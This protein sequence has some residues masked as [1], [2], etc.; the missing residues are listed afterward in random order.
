MNRDFAEMLSALSEA[1]AEHPIVSAHALAV[2]GFPRATGDLDIW[3]RPS[4]ENAAHVLEAL[5]AFG[6]A[7]NHSK[8]R[9]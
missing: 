7:F 8:R 3:I 9:L 2:H 4:R 5:R 6:A 1:D